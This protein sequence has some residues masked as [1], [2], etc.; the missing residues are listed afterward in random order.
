MAS[1]WGFRSVLRCVTA[2]FAVTAYGCATT[3]VSPPETGVPNTQATTVITGPKNPVELQTASGY[4][5]VPKSFSDLPAWQKTDFISAR[6]AFL[7]S[8][9]SWSK[10]DGYKLISTS[11]PYSGTVSDWMPACTSIQAATDT[12]MIAKVFETEFTPYFINPTDKQSKLTG[13]FEPELE[14][15]YRP[16]AGFS[17]AVPGIP[18]DLVRVDPSEFDPKFAKGKVWGRVIEG[19]LEFYPDRKDIIDEPSKALGYASPGEIFYLQIQGSGRLKFPDGR[20]IR[21]A[22]AAHNHKPF[23]S[24]ARHLIDTG[25]IQTHQAG[26]N[27][28]L[29][30][31][32]E[33]GPQIAQDAMNVNPRYVWFTPQEIKDPSKGPN[34]AQGIPLTAMASMA[35]DPRYHAYGAPIFIDTKVPAIPGDWKGREF[36]NL[37]IAQDTGGAIKGILRGDLFFGSGD[38]AG[39]RAAS[40][41][42]DVAMWVLLPKSVASAMTEAQLLADSA[43]G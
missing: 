16:E 26:M 22:F 1:R 30:W 10:R 18:E 5:M 36:R 20:V 28:I 3:T 4:S 14:V 42:H 35:V 40:M 32:D 39:G 34:G 24:I 27:S 23:V 38:D 7:E 17:Q 43:D 19:E 37:V 9:Q 31:M 2:I 12:R 13:Y 21:A 11:A 25:Q 8:C 6:S 29:N 15:R 41:N 33:V